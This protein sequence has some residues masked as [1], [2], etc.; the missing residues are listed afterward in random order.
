MISSAVL[1]HAPLHHFHSLRA[2]PLPARLQLQTAQQQRLWRIA[3]LGKVD[4]EAQFMLNRFCN[5]SQITAMKCAPICVFSFALKLLHLIQRRFIEKV[6]VADKTLFRL[7][8]SGFKN[9]E[10]AKAFC[11]TVAAND[12]DCIT[13]TLN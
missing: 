9:L 1:H 3:G 11:L 13:A 12:V 7:Q 6:E 5:L 10:E 2:F 8:T 4:I